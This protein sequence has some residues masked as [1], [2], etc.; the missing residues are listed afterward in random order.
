MLR[1]LCVHSYRRSRSCNGVTL[2][3]AAALCVLLIPSAPVQA[4]HNCKGE[5]EIH[6]VIPKPGVFVDTHK[7][8][9]KPNTYAPMV[10]IMKSPFTLERRLDGQT[11]LAKCRKLAL[12]CSR[13]RHRKK[14]VRAY[15]MKT[16]GKGKFVKAHRLK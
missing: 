16:N 4:Q 1:P 11:T 7:I 10:Y 12:H 9:Q 6:K 8:K 2:S 3:V 5:I 15:C 14:H 13:G